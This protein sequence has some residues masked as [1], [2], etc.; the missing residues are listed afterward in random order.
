VRGLSAAEIDRS[1]TTFCDPT[2]VIFAQDR[3]TLGFGAN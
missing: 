1:Q 3:K 2:L